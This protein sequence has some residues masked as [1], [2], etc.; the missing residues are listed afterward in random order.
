MVHVKQHP[1]LGVNGRVELWA[2]NV[3]AHAAADAALL[4]PDSGAAAIGAQALRLQLVTVC[5]GA[6][7]AAPLVTTGRARGF[8]ALTLL[9]ARPALR[10]KRVR[11]RVLLLARVLLLI[12][13][14]PLP[15]ALPAALRDSAPA[16]R[17]LLGAGA[18]RGGGAALAAGAAA[19]AR[20][21]PGASR[22][23]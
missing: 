1:V 16:L 3:L 19:R 23:G 20:A 18:A 4:G 11:L 14:T 10:F 15:A 2:Q 22:C 13:L 7:C 17:G 12:R 8:A 6:H 5:D 21:A 9:I